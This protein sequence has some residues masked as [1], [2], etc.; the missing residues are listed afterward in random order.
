M[1]TI[2]VESEGEVLVVTINRPAVRNAIDGPTAAALAAT[3]RAFDRD[4]HHAVA[5]L[6]G[7]AGTFCAGADLK[8][9]VARCREAG[10]VVNRRAGRLR[11]SPHCYNSEEELERGAAAFHRFL[12]TGHWSMDDLDDADVE[13]YRASMPRS[14]KAEGES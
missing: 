8:A 5:V 3:F 7:A 10:I 4:E 1:S 14:A 11:V 6:T 2:E 13:A 9:L 12:K